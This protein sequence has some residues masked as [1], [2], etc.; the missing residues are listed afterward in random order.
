LVCTGW[1]DG[2]PGTQIWLRFITIIT[3]NHKTHVANHLDPASR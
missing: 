2:E 1:G 3:I